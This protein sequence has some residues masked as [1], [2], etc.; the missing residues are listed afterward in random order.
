MSPLF[1]RSA[2]LRRGFSLVELLVVIGIIGVLVAMLLPAVQSA[3]ESARGIQCVNQM[4]QLGLA[5]HQHVDAREVFPTGGDTPWPF[6]EDNLVNGK[7]HGPRRQGLG[8]GYQIMPYVEESAAQ[9][10][11]TTYELIRTQ[12]PLMQCPSR[13]QGGQAEGDVSQFGAYAEIA[14]LATAAGVPGVGDTVVSALSDYAASTPCGVWAADDPTNA[15]A[16][17]GAAPGMDWPFPETDDRRYPIFQDAIWQV[18]PGRQYYGVIVRTPWDCG[19]SDF[20]SRCLPPEEQPGRPPGVT[21]VIGFGKITDGASKTM[22]LGE[23]L[24]AWWVYWGGQI[25]DDRGWSDGWDYDTV[26]TT[27]FPPQRDTDSSGFDSTFHYLA[28]V[29]HFGAAHPGGINAVFADGSVHRIAY[30]VDPVTFNLLGDRRDGF[31]VSP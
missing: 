5:I 24:V 17:I 22:M 23:K 19:S 8:W 26:R 10:A 14:D 6:V 7:P 11:T 20:F 21:N 4:K 15:G 29:V 27:C 18:Q 12:M 3:R 1:R 31:V 2:T 13:R 28:E 25:S 16:E 9:Q 30:D